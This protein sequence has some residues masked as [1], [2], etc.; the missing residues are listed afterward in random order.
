[1]A[2]WDTVYLT[3]TTT[4]VMMM[5]MSRLLLPPTR[6][7]YLQLTGPSSCRR[8]KPNAVSFCLTPK[9]PP[10]MPRIQ[11]SNPPVWLMLLI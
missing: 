7:W 8:A 4:T 6:T 10:K 2:K 1:M 11:N 3:T 9:S 5:M